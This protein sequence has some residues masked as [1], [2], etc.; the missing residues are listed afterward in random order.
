MFVCVV[1]SAEWSTTGLKIRFPLGSASSSLAPGTICVVFSDPLAGTP[2]F[3][4][5]DTSGYV[6]GIKPDAAAHIL[7]GRQARQR[8]SAN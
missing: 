7:I 4:D 8:C 2:V 5:V 1:L 6:A 3:I